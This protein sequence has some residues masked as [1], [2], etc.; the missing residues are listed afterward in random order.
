VST[1]SV[2]HVLPHVHLII[3]VKFPETNY[4]I[5]QQLLEFSDGFWFW[6]ELLVN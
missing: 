1:Q 6:W 3:L 2:Q 4:P 5:L